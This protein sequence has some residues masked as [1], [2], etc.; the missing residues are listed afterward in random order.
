MVIFSPFHDE[1]CSTVLDYLKFLD[2]VILRIIMTSIKS[3]L[4]KCRYK[5]HFQVFRHFHYDQIKIFEYGQFVECGTSCK[6]LRFIKDETNINFELHSNCG[7]YQERVLRL[8]SELFY[9]Y[10]RSI[11]ELIIT[12]NISSVLPLAASVCYLSSIHQYISCKTE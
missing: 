12:V 1:S 5:N 3:T 11:T 9:L 10:L 4:D 6:W 2:K 7:L 8:L